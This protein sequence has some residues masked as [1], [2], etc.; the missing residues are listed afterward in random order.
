MFVSK[1]VGVS[2]VACYSYIMHSPAVIT[3]AKYLCLLLKEHCFNFFQ[4]QLFITKMQVC[5][6]SSWYNQNKDTYIKEITVKQPTLSL[7]LSHTHSLSLS[8]L[9][10]SLSLS[11]NEMISRF[12]SIIKPGIL[13]TYKQLEQQQTKNQQ[14]NHRPRF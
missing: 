9:S 7:S 8:L 10:L 5:T 14:Q 12:D 11:L 4:E 3:L 1:I 6:T 2:D 13:H